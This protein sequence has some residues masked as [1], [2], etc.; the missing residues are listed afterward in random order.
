M[1]TDTPNE[2]A[3]RAYLVYLQDP[4]SLIDHETIASLESDLSS[5]TNPLNRLKLRTQLE[6]LQNPDTAA[7]EQGFLDHAKA[8]ATAHDVGPAALRAEGVSTS[9]LRRAGFS[10]AG[11]KR[12]PSRSKA[13]KDKAPKAKAKTSLEEI[14]TWMLKQRKAFTV[15]E[16]AAAT[17]ASRASASKALNGLYEEGTVVDAGEAERTG[18]GRP[19]LAYRVAS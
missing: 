16:A 17:G 4:K 6:R 8:W 19:A 14:T 15:A 10:V 12:K 9:V 13:S 2:D 3:V 1:A 18:P 5:E 7:V 11:G